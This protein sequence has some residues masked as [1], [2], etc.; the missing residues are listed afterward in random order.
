MYS[1]FFALKGEN[2]VNELLICGTINPEPQI[3]ER[4]GLHNSSQPSS[5]GSSSVVQKSRQHI[6]SGSK[7]TASK[8][9]AVTNERIYNDNM[10]EM[11]F[12]DANIR[13]YIGS[14]ASVELKLKIL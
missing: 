13:K 2:V 6:D 5:S 1:L 11:I 12:I 10:N 9:G 7:S 4:K 8:T 3:Q 14:V